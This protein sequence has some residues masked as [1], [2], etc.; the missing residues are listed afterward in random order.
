MNLPN[1]GQPDEGARN[2]A[3]QVYSP[4]IT[5]PYAFSSRRAPFNPLTTP[6]AFSS[7]RAPFNPLGVRLN[8]AV[9]VYSPTITTLYSQVFWTALDAVPLPQ[10]VVDRYV[11]LAITKSYTS[12]CPFFFKMAQNLDLRCV[13]VP[14][15]WV[16]GPKHVSNPE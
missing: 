2:N 14:A 13:L 3:V 6:Y 10:E 9:Q 12:T 7:G 1:A 8:N 5:T 16:L 15:P 11:G 4:N